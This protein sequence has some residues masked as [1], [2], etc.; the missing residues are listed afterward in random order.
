LVKGSKQ[1]SI[2]VPR[3]DRTPH[4]VGFWLKKRLV[5]TT[6]SHRFADGEAR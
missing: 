2:Y 5:K 3:T 6:K 4:D 1:L